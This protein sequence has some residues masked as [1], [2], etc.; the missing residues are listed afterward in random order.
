MLII[1]ISVV[2]RVKSEIILLQFQLIYMI[3]VPESQP[4]AVL[5]Y[6]LNKEMFKALEGVLGTRDRQQAAMLEAKR[7]RLSTSSCSSPC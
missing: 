7:C 4:S 1:S 2:S 6:V 3:S 5:I